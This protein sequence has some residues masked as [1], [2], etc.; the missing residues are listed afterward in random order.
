MLKRQVKK[1]QQIVISWI[2]EHFNKIKIVSNETFSDV[3][4]TRRQQ[5][6]DPLHNDFLQEHNQTFH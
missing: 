4:D 3:I 1:T 2:L 5:C 6:L